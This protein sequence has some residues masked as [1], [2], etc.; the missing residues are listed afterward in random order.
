MPPPSAFPRPLPSLILA[1]GFLLSALPGLGAEAL[2]AARVSPNLASNIDRPLRYRPQDGDFVIENGPE[3]FNRSL[4][5]GNT[6]FRADG[7]DKP[8]FVLYL[9]GR[10]GNLRLG[11]SSAAGARWL[12]QAAQVITR[13]R[14][15]ELLYEIRDPLLGPGGVLKIEVLA[16]DQTEGLVV[17]ATGEGI[18]PGLDLVWAY[19]GITGKRG[20]RDG[21]IGTEKVPIGQYFQL[22][23]GMCQDN[24]VQIDGA[25]FT[26][27]A[28]AATIAGQAPA[29]AVLSV[30]DARHWPD[31]ANLLAD[32]TPPTLPLLVA[33]GPL[34][35][36]IARNCVSQ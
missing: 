8:E 17:R 13:Y 2:A 32:R 7:G 5:G 35:G 14:P 3:F 1:G 12:Q 33:R 28:K 20:A 21:D 26:V 9:P 16:Y 19:G 31:L 36:A 18:S 10:G 34:V 25:A 4:Y 29:G 23:P 24:A 6:A 22:E 30:G 11:V 15:G 27:R